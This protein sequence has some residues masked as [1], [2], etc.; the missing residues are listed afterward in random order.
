[1]ETAHATRHRLELNV[2]ERQSDI[3]DARLLALRAEI[4]LAEGNPDAAAGFAGQAV[5]RHA[6][7]Q[8]LE[9]LA[10]IE[11]ARGHRDPAIRLYERLLDRATEWVLDV[12]RPTF[13]RV[14]RTRHTLAQLLEDKGDSATAGALYQALGALWRH[15]DEGTVEREVARRVG[16]A[17]ASS[18]LVP[19][20]TAAQLELARV[21]PLRTATQ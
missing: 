19:R 10:R 9:R 6:S 17:V 15:A 8:H 21:R 13:F 5:Q 14:V 1:M 2:A 16:R 4:A 12:D 11:A 18:R 3:A 7:V 20:A